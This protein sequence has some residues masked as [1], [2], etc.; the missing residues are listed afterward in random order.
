LVTE[1]E[2]GWVFDAADPQALG[3]ALRRALLALAAP[4]NAARVRTN[5]ATRIARYTYRETTAGLV[6]ALDAITAGR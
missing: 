1:G 5:V 2:P 6:A 3:E 4:A